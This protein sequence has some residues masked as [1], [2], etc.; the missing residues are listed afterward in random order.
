MIFHLL[1]FCL[2]SAITSTPNTSQTNK[3]TNSSHRRD[4]IRDKTSYSQ[5]DKVSNNASTTVNSNR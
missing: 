4:K 2:R 1:L 3:R 5:R